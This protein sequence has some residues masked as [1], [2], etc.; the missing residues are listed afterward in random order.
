M[1][2]IRKL[3]T[4]SDY[5]TLLSVIFSFLGLILYIPNLIY[6]SIIFD[7]LDGYVARKTNTVSEFG[8][9]LD[10]LADAISFGLVPAYFLYNSSL[11]SIFAGLFFLLCGI[12]RLARF[13]IIKSNEFIGLPIPA[14][15]LILVSS[16]QL[17]GKLSIIFAFILG[18]LMISDI[19]YPKFKNKLGIVIFLL[20]IVLAIFNIPHLAFIVGVAYVIYGMIR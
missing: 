13:N 7:S 18:F 12:L 10:S 1:L 5:I 4:I 20:A 3:I 17:F 2:S 6:L 14:G 9:N 15:A 8:A 11:I 19:R 16:I